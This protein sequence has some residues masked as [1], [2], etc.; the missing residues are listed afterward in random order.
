[1]KNKLSTILVL[2]SAAI[3]L[4]CSKCKEPKP[5]TDKPKE[6]ITLYNKLGDVKDYCFFKAGTYWVYKNEQTGD[7]DSHWVSSSA[8]YESTTK[9]TEDYSMHI[10]LKQE[11]FDMRINTNFVDGWGNKCY[12]EMFTT[13]STVNSFPEPKPVYWITCRKSWQSDGT[14][15]DIFLKPYTTDPKAIVYQNQFYEKLT[16]NGFEYDSVRVMHV[17][18][19]GV[20]P[21]SK[22][23][24]GGTAN[25]DYY[26]AKN[27]GIVKIYIQSFRLLDATPFNQTWS[28]IRKKI[29]Q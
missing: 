9:G 29:L 18:G 22:V 25:T 19:D 21:E 20:Y 26:F 13:G 2:F 23:P 4:V 7:I 6:P 16:I 3:C 17:G 28:V 10:T 24:T 12:W 14:Y 11:L 1:M 8:I 5:P 15:N 27:Y